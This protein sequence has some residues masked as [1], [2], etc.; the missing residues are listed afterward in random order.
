[1]LYLPDVMMGATAQ[2]WRARDQAI[3]AYNQ[4]RARIQPFMR[5]AFPNEY[6]VADKPP[7]N[8][9]NKSTETVQRSRDSYRDRVNKYK[10]IEDQVLHN[11]G[12]NPAVLSHAE[13]LFYLTQ[14]QAA[15]DRGQTPPVQSAGVAAVNPMLSLFKAAITGGDTRAAVQSMRLTDWLPWALVG[16]AA[17]RLIIRRRAT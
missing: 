8:P 15:I 2:A 5:A 10:K 11:M 17:I 12:Y 9:G 14:Q 4:I 13:K 1:M 16:V 7:Y 3:T 6:A